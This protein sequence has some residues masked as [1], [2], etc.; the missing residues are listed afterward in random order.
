MKAN[1][2]Q[3]ELFI[4]SQIENAGNVSPLVAKSS[5]EDLPHFYSSSTV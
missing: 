1:G 2:L 5:S 3:E 4:A